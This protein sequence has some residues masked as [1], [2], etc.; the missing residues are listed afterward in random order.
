MNINTTII[1][2][3]KIPKTNLCFSIR[4]ISVLSNSLLFIGKGD[5]VGVFSPSVD[6]SKD[7][8]STSSI[9]RNIV[10]RIDRYN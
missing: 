1:G 8:I 4:S 6:V 10:P 9:L 7:S 5:G 2:I 3:P